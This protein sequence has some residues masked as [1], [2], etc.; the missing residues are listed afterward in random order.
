ML[1]ERERR[2]EPL[3]ERVDAQRLQPPRLGAQ[4]LRLGQ[5]LQSWT[6]PER[7]RELD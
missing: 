5:P 3:L 6:A 7:Q 4:P 1:P 2:L